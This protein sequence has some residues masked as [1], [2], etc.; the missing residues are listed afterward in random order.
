MIQVIYT[1]SAARD[2][3][4]GEVFR[5]V[6]KSATNNGRDG[7]SGFLVYFNDR[8]FQVLEG[9]ADAVDRLMARL[10]ADPRHRSISVVERRE[11]ATPSF[12]SW[13]MKRLFAAPQTSVLDQIDPHL[14]LA[15]SNVRAALQNFLTVQTATSDAA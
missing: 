13:R 1:S 2:L 6:T 4:S 12:P 11:V 3:A 15:P 8:F 5:I 7:L 9:E 10:E 14:A